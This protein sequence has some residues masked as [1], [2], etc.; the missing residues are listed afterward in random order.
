MN[1]R[2]RTENLLLSNW[3]LV[4]F[5][6]ISFF[7]FCFRN[8]DP[9]AYPTLYAEDGV[10]TSDLINNG[11]YDTAFNTRLFPILGF[12]IFYK[13]GLLIT[14]L[15]LDGNILYLPF[16]YFILANLFLSLLVVFTFRIFSRYLS[17]SSSLFIIIFMI[18]LPVGID[19]NEIF[20]RILNLGFIFPVLQVVLLVEL[21]R[22]NISKVSVIAI[23]IFSG[24]SGLTFPIGLAISAIF[25]IYLSYLSLKNEHKYNYIFSIILLIIPIAYFVFS[26][27]T[28]AFSS[29]GGADLPFKF[30]S[31]VEFAVARSIIY[32]LVF[33]FYNHLNDFM[34]FGIFTLTAGL[35][36]ALFVRQYQSNDNNGVISLGLVLWSCFLL[37]LCAMIVMR[38]GLTF[39]FNSYSSTFP[40]R[41]FT[42]LN[43]L[44]ILCLTFTIDS[45]NKKKYIYFLLLLP[46]LLTANKRFEMADPKMKMDSVM[47][48]T[49]ATCSA[50]TNYDSQLVKIYIPPKGWSMLIPKSLLAD[51]TLI[52]CSNIPFYNIY[53]LTKLQ[54][55]VLSYPKFMPSVSTTN[56]KD[57][58]IN[59]SIELTRKL[60]IST[61]VVTGSDPSLLFSLESEGSNERYSF[62]SFTLI[63]NAEGNIQVY[64]RLYAEPELSESKSLLIPIKKGENN[65]NLSF[66][67][68]VIKESIRLDFPEIMNARYNI[69]M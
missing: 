26:I 43:L 20:G 48:W 27:N 57:I 5:F 4:T 64:Y 45:F 44:F 35:I 40:D 9:I 67:D 24:I 15:F 69:I 28:E 49:L 58:K 31:F 16:V 63:S 52:N 25:I 59:N 6:I 62:I 61:V 10:W 12:V 51:T 30:E 22:V 17:L 34:V 39:I 18:L 36:T 66:S 21:C 46:V 3:G 56:L 65:I 7:A 53:P 38:N 41:Y 1:I 29:K 50:E 55:P 37:Y 42:G 68:T 32:P 8:L 23:T 19:S 33:Y 14:E 13:I 11:F 47:P 54:P 60:D 2:S